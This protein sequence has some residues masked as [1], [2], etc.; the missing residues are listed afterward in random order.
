MSASYPAATK[1]F[2]AKSDGSGQTIFAAH[3][4][5]LQDEV[6]AVENG[7]RNGVA[8]DLKPSVAGAQDLGSSGLPWGI[9]RVG[10][11]QLTD[12]TTLTVATDAATVTASYHAL[13]TEGAAGTDDCATLTAGAGVAAGFI[14]VLRAANV[15]HVVTLKDGTGNLLLSG[16]ARLGT[17]DATITLLYDG[18]NWRELGRSGSSGG[19]LTLLKAGNGTSAA[20][21]ATTVDSI[22]LPTLTANDTLL[23][24]FTCESA[25][26]QTTSPELYSVTD[27]AVIGTLQS[28]NS[29]NLAATGIIQGTVQLNQR[30]GITTNYLMTSS[31]YSPS[32]NSVF[33]NSVPYVATAVWT[34][35][36][37]LAL[38]HGGV[39]AG[40]TFKWAWSVYRV[41]GQ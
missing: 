39:T 38:R 18:T 17:T 9:A 34:S 3:V 1:S 19:S 8:H 36:W 29:G 21:G 16:D 30:Q 13:E 35:G 7:L 11:L 23:I 40:G 6:V 41:T 5:D 4:N 15:A 25:T 27:A 2:S 32:G 33:F 14:V 22:A 28:Q 12:A 37:T 26:Q 24:Y 20:A 31:G 10:S